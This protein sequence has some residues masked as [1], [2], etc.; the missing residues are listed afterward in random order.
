[1]S[2]I[3]GYEVWYYDKDLDT[4]GNPLGWQELKIASGPQGPPGATGP[5]GVA[6]IQGV[7]GPTGAQGPVGPPGPQGGMAQL[8]PPVEQDASSLLISPWQVLPSSSVVF[9]VDAWNRCQLHG[10]VYYP[11]GNPG[12]YSAIM[13]CPPGT[14]P[15]FVWTLSAVEDVIPPRMYRV[16]VHP[17]GNIYLRFPPT[18]ST[19]Q[20][21][22][23]NISWIVGPIA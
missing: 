11:N 15:A 21:F 10:E 8:I 14:V 12:D 22:L 5:T 9:W 18:G 13:Q 19:G 4:T 23:D 17:D 1:M 2:Q 3:T 7:V 16:D 6:G 20:I